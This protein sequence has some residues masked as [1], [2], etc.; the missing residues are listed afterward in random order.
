MN[1][2]MLE[3]TGGFPESEEN[4]KDIPRLQVQGGGDHKMESGIKDTEAGWE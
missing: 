2:V 1:K 3:P 4:T